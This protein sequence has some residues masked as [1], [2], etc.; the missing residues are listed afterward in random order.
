MT[1]AYSRKWGPAVSGYS[2]G[3]FTLPHGIG[4]HTGQGNVYM[5]AETDSRVLITDTSGVYV[6]EWGLPNLGRQI[7]IDSV[8]NIAYVSC[9]SNV[10]VLKYDI[11][12]P[13][14]VASAGSFGVGTGPAGI[15]LFN[16]ELYICL[17][18]TSKIAVHDLSGVWQ[19]DLTG[20][21]GINNTTDCVVVG[22]TVYATSYNATPTGRIL[23]LDKTTGA[24]TGTWEPTLGGKIFHQLFGIAHTNGGFYVCDGGPAAGGGSHLLWVLD[25]NGN[26]V[27]FVHASGNYGTGDGYFQGASNSPLNCAIAG[28][29]IYVTDNA[30][31]GSPSTS[32]VQVF[33]LNLTEEVWNVFPYSWST[34]AAIWNI[35]PYSWGVTANKAL[36]HYTQGKRQKEF[37]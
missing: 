30:D 36:F 17:P 12:N 16:S 2:L 9:Y 35:L 6:G 7:H 33:A 5:V 18:G 27:E 3:S 24:L 22:D 25:S 37:Q 11:S 31:N 32:R 15:S 10:N 28:G 34:L 4:V 1:V 23:L 19:R 13:A 26:A 29:E 14:S 20:G 21:G 8:N